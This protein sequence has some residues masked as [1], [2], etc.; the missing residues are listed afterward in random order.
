MVR[1]RNDVDENS[2][3]STRNVWRSDGSKRRRK[4]EK[5]ESSIAPIL[6]VDSTPGEVLQHEL[7]MERHAAKGGVRELKS[8]RELI[9]SLKEIAD[10]TERVEEQSIATMEVKRLAGEV[11][12]FV[13]LIHS[14]QL[15]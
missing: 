4:S 1:S 9:K 10:I 11:R 7:W 12:R 13:T 3:F 6:T 2:A 14:T 8:L 5:G 15:I